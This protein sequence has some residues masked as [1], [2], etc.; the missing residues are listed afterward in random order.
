MAPARNAN[1]QAIPPDLL[2]KFIAITAINGCMLLQEK[3]DYKTILKAG[4]ASVA[5]VI[6]TDYGSK[7]S[8]INGDKPLDDQQLGNGIG[9]D[10][11]LQISGRCEK[12]VPEE[13]LKKIKEFIQS[14]SSKK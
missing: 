3:V 8:N 11:S 6:Y 1:A 10:L 9:I 13:D 12:L 2:Q 4:I 5:G 14:N 7:I